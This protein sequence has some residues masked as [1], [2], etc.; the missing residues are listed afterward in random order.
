MIFFKRRGVYL[1]RIQTCNIDLFAY[2]GRCCPPSHRWPICLPGTSSGSGRPAPPPRTRYSA[3]PGWGR[4]CWSWGTG[5]CVWKCKKKKK[6]EEDH[7]KVFLYFNSISRA[8]VSLTGPAW[9]WSSRSGVGGTLATVAGYRGK[10]ERASRDR[11][12]RLDCWGWTL[13]CCRADRCTRDSARTG[14]GSW[15]ACGR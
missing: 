4:R 3:Q 13:S 11:R 6:S 12:A 14:K 2:L 7:R 15:N 9:W 5:T 1:K 8:G 10:P